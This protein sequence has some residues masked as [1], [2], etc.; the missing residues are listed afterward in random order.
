MQN[1]KKKMEY[2]NFSANFV[3]KVKNAYF[4]QKF[5]EKYIYT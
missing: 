5:N 4:C 1:Y 3:K 2:A